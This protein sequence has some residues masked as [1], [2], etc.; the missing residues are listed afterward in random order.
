MAKK[1]FK[2]KYNQP[3]FVKSDIKLDYTFKSP[4]DTSSFYNESDNMDKA[5]QK[6]I[7]KI[8]QKSANEVLQESI[9]ETY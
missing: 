9:D 8:S 4:S 3:G 6:S 7:D 1:I 5:F 2:F